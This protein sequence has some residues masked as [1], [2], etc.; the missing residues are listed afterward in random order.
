M[1]DILCSDCGMPIR[2]PKFRPSPGRMIYCD[3][4][5]KK[6]IR[7][8][9]VER[10]ERQLSDEGFSLNKKDEEIARQ[11]KDLLVK[12]SSGNSFLS[13]FIKKDE[14]LLTLL[15]MRMLK[16]KK[17]EEKILEHMLTLQKE[18]RKI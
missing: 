13:Q 1:T 6:R 17:R 4:C 7:I 14:K 15:M 8:M 12:K 10:F 11:I 2:K 9:L 18:K 16:N 5:E 3:N